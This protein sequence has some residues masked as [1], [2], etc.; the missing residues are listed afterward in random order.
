M[1]VVFGMGKGVV[2]EEIMKDD[3]VNQASETGN[4]G[5]SMLLD[6]NDVQTGN[7]DSTSKVDHPSWS[8]RSLSDSDINLSQDPIDITKEV[9]AEQEMQEPVYYSFHPQMYDSDYD[10]SISG[11]EGDLKTWNDDDDLLQQVDPY[12]WQQDPYHEDDE[13][14]ENTE[15]FTELDDLLEHFPFQNDELNENVVG[16][17]A[18]V[19]A[20]EEQL[21]RIEH[22]VD[23]E[24][25]RPRKRKRENEGE[26][27]SANVLPFGKIKQEEKGNICNV[28]RAD[29]SLSREAGANNGNAKVLANTV[30]VMLEQ[31]LWGCQIIT[32]Y[33]R[34]RVMKRF[35][36]IS[37]DDL[38]DLD[39]ERYVWIDP[40]ALPLAS[41]A[42]EVYKKLGGRWGSS[43]F[44]DMVSDGPMS[45]GKV[46][47]LTESLHRVIES[48]IVS[49]HNRT[50]RIIATE[51]AYWAPNI[52]SI[53]VNSESNPLERKDAEGPNLDESLENKEHLDVVSRVLRED[54]V[55]RG[56]MEKNL[57]YDDGEILG[58]VH[59]Q[60]IVVL[61]HDDNEDVTQLMLLKKDFIIGPPSTHSG[62]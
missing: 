57:E 36:V 34:K 46:C 13:A 7:I 40:V 21:E 54:D 28:P 8:S 35:D 1:E 51:F 15:L 30:Q 23:E 59:S 50:Y 26:S 3:E 9:K 60:V 25:E 41:W 49:Y 62:Y 24:I 6:E 45:H 42:P 16:V 55:R 19:V 22:E 56:F 33:I 27:A 61:Y 43:V 18:P 12:D 29:R 37:V 39:D 52:E 53:E 32:R 20:V 17:D 44:T 11:L 2:I 58:L 10:R 5:Q 14:E 47:V 48:F 31:N 4:R 38:Y